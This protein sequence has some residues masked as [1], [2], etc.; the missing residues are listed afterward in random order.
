MVSPGGVKQREF[1][2]S[3]NA[4]LI[5]AA[6]GG[7]RKFAPN[8][9]PRGCVAGVASTAPRAPVEP[10]DHLVDV[11]RGSRVSGM[12]I[13]SAWAAALLPL[14]LVG[15]VGCLFA[16]AQSF[17]QLQRSLPVM[18]LLAVIGLSWYGGLGSGVF[19]G[20]LGAVALWAVPIA[21]QPAADAVAWP[22]TVLES[23]ALLLAALLTGGLS[24]ARER[25]EVAL[26]ERD[27][28]LALVSQQLPAILWS[29]DTDLHVTTSM[30]M[31]GG[32]PQV[33]PSIGTFLAF[34]DPSNPASPAHA[35]HA[36]ALRGVACTYETTWRDRSFQSHLEPLRNPDGDIIGVVG[37]AVDITDRKS[38]EEHL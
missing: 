24:D 10:S 13:K 20:L 4:V 35:V 3:S 28:R 16:F 26:A 38:A 9:L 37:V 34:L 23:L 12:A 1:E 33:S 27:A 11:V 14:A 30:G 19:A 31:A 36:E 22:V 29:T 32:D 5:D 7:S 8:L 25:A 2:S 21:A 15:A 17:E 18:L 6:W